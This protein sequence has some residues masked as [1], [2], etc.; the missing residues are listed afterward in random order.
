MP[1][2]ETALNPQAYLRSIRTPKNPVSGR[3]LRNFG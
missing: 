1:F 2:P 3:Q